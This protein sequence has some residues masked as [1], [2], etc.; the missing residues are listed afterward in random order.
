MSYYDP[1]TRATIT[2]H[3]A[4]GNDLALRFLEIGA[5]LAQRRRT[6]AD[7]LARLYGVAAVHPDDGWVD[8]ERNKLQ[9]VYPTFQREEVRA[10]DA[11]ALDARSDTSIRGYRI[12][13]VIRVE[14]HDLLDEVIAYHFRDTGARWRPENPL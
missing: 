6:E 2:P 9:L 12:V 10:G 3:T 1:H 4:A 14:R 13:R 7:T 5:N 11:I 8:R